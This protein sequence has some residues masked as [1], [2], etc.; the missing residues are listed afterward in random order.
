MEKLDL[1]TIINRVR[2][3]STSTP[4]SYKGHDGET[5]EFD[6][7]AISATIIGAAI[8]C[9]CP[10]PPRFVPTATSYFA[11]TFGQ[12]IQ[13]TLS[14]INEA[15]NIRTQMAYDAACTVW[16][17]RYAMVHKP[18]DL[19]ALIT[20]LTV[21]NGHGSMNSN[22]PTMLLGSLNDEQKDA[23]DKLVRSVNLSCSQSDIRGGI[24]Q[25]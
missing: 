12:E 6:A 3:L 14:K 1:T 21:S 8:G 5:K 13:S 19:D 18:C 7:S 17:D 2:Q 11:S 9:H 22:F 15:V 4:I 20:R 25:V 16:L 24:F 10:I 23:L